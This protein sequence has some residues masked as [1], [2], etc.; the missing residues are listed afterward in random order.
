VCIAARATRS[1]VSVM[2]CCAV[3]CDECETQLNVMAF[4]PVLR[5]IIH[6]AAVFHCVSGELAAHQLTV[7]P[8]PNLVVVD[9]AGTV[10]ESLFWRGVG[11]RTL[12]D[13]RAALTVGGSATVL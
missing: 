8:F 7:N 4:A 12:P 2:L 10:I 9:I 11:G 3:L 5:F 6:A 13:K 1:M